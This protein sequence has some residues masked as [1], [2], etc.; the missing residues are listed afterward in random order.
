MKSTIHGIGLTFLSV[1]DVDITARELLPAYV[2]SRRTQFRSNSKL[3]AAVLTSW[4]WDGPVYETRR[5]TWF[6]VEGSTLRP[7]DEALAMQIEEGYLKQKPF[8]TY[9]DARSTT[10]SEKPANTTI[11]RVA[12][13]G[14]LK[15][16]TPSN[17]IEISTPPKNDGGARPYRLLGPHM[18]TVVT[19][20]D[21]D[22]AWLSTD[23]LMSRV[24]S[25][26]YQTFGG[27]GH[28]AGTKIV[29]GYT[30]PGKGKENIEPKKTSKQEPTA[31]VSTP[32]THDTIRKSMNR[33]SAPPSTRAGEF[34]TNIFGDKKEV[35][36]EAVR[37]EDEKEIRDDYKEREDENQ[38]R[39]ITHLIFVTH[40]IGQR[41]GI[42]TE[43]MNFVHDINVLRQTLKT[44][45]ANSADLQALNY[46]VDQ[47]PKNCRVQVLPV[48]WRHMLDFPKKGVRQ[49][50]HE[51]DV[52]DAL[53][54]LDDEA[55]PS[56]ENITVESIPFVRSLLTDL[57]LDIL[58]FQS[59]MYKQH[60]SKICVQECNRIYRKFLD[61]NPHFDGKVY[62]LGHSLGSA[63]FF[64]LLCNQSRRRS[65]FDTKS[66]QAPVNKDL[67]FEFEVEDFFAIGSP[68]G[69]FQML[70]GRTIA[71]E[72]GNDAE[73]NYPVSAPQVSQI[74]N[75]IHPTDP[76][77][78]RLEPLIS[79]AMTSMKPQPIPYT[80]KGIFG[81]GVSDGITSLGV[82]VG[83]LWSSLSSGIA[84]NLL[85]RSIGLNPDEVRKLSSGT[86]MKDMTGVVQSTNGTA[87]DGTGSPLSPGMERRVTTEKMQLLAKSTQAADKDGSG[88]NASVLIDDDLETLFAGF[89]KSRSA[90]QANSDVD[91]AELEEKSRK[92][93][94]ED[95]KVRALNRNGRVDYIIQE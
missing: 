68:I 62:L 50:R 64:D 26:M 89:Q 2:G 25:T 35:E 88:T 82:K 53:V 55:Y 93:R 30:E 48:C 27:G 67:Q 58:L 46:E 40:G 59:T 24:S 87:L 6:Y 78:Y 54:S 84:S 44:V 14:S 65:R 60:I 94:K 45:Y 91:Q 17:P 79:P 74:Y 28:L 1:F 69:V 73:G 11:P 72:Q 39:E 32:P 90:Q 20:Q 85:S 51:E 16:N 8:R 80:K 75:I 63:I 76:V 33:R 15:G 36:A 23:K 34:A 49:N 81:T 13:T 41:L 19:F 92:L 22:V 70:N 10:G 9:S 7:C 12:S 3:S 43:S 77:C 47:L 57:V 38:D 86:E 4:Q 18:N 56:L 52:S 21:A 42:R 29:R 71:A 37:K 66:S 83:G 95:A 5:G 31:P 61:R